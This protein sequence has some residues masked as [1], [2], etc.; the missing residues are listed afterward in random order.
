MAGQISADP[1]GGSGTTLRS[2]PYPTYP[3]SLSIFVRGRNA[4]LSGV[5]WDKEDGVNTD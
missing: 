1:V 5:E 4:L 2:A 3:L